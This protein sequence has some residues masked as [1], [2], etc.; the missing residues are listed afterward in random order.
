MLTSIA[1]YCPEVPVYLRGPESIIGGYDAELKVFAN[2]SNFGDAYNDIMDKAFA[3]GFDSVVCAN[4]DIVLTP[5]SYRY[6]ME[7]VSQLRLE[8]GEPVGWVSARCDAARPVQNIRSNPFNQEM[9]YFKYPFEDAIMPMECLSPIFAWIGRDAW[10]CFKFPPLNW[11]SDDV[12]CMDLVRKGYAHFVSASYVHH[13][14]SNTIGM[15]FKD[16][17]E[18]AMPWLKENR[19]EYAS[20]WFD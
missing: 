1:E 15:E 2:A 10:D 19:P 6:L 13:I 11:Y 4:D 12:H 5:T 14:G 20:A 7:D 18:D 16:L 17:H 3:D 9:H 8:T